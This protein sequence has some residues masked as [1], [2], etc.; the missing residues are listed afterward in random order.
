MY[1]NIYIYV[2]ILCPTATNWNASVSS[3]DQQFHHE[4]KCMKCH[5]SSAPMTTAMYLPDSY[6]K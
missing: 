3:L 5:F 2:Y 4:N 6:N 1:I